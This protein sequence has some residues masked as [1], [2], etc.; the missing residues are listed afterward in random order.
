MRG[1]L[2]GGL[3]CTWVILYIQYVGMIAMNN[4]KNHN[5]VNLVAVNDIDR[6]NNC[7]KCETVIFNITNCGTVGPKSVI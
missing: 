6:F 4:Y 7:F 3:N 1:L 5:L 2:L